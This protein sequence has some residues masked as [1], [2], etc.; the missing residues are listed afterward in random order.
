[1]I[2]SYVILFCL[3]MVVA[4]SSACRSIKSEPPPSPEVIQFGITPTIWQILSPNLDFCNQTITGAEFLPK[5]DPHQALD[6]SHV[7]L[8]FDIPINDESWSENVFQVG[9]LE[10]VLILHPDTDFD[11]WDS[12][13]LQKV[14]TSPSPTLSKWTY[15]D[16]HDLR[17]LFDQFILKTM[18][19]DPSLKI[20][21]DPEQMIESVSNN[22]RSIGYIPKQ[23]ASVESNIITAQESLITLP[24]LVFSNT[25][26]LGR[27][28]EFIACLQKYDQR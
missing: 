14:Y 1:M 25:E 12:K 21:A 16:N 19:V 18:D 8:I 5:I 17:I 23:L 9:I 4:S 24:V 20:V 28:E 22:A 15:P 3:A 11:A 13:S 27:T 7:N 2:R 26:P 6:F 10:L